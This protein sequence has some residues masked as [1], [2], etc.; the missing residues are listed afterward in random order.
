MFD[1][2]LDSVDEFEDALKGPTLDAFHLGRLGIVTYPQ[3]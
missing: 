1:V 3:R 2:G